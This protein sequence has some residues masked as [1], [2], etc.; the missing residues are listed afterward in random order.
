MKTGYRG[1]LMGLLV[2]GCGGSTLSSGECNS[3]E[4]LRGGQCVVVA[5]CGPGTFQLNGVCLPN[6]TG[7]SAGGIGYGG[8]NGNTSGSGGV[9]AG[10]AGASGSAA[11]A[12]A[13]GGVTAAGTAG[14]DTVH[15]AGMAGGDTAGAAGSDAVGGSAAGVGGSAV[16][17]G[18]SAGAIDGGRD[19]GNYLIDAAHDNLQP[20]DAI[21]SPLTPRWSATFSDLITYPVIAQGRVFVGTNDGTLTAL[22]AET[23]DTLWGPSQF[24]SSDSSARVMVAAE[25]DHLYA[26]MGDGLLSGLDATNGH[27]TWS[28]PLQGQYFFWSAPVAAGGSV[29]VNGL[30]SGGTTYAVNG[31]TGVVSWTAGTFDGS[32]GTV[33]VAGDRVYEAEACDQLSAFESAT[34]K[35][36]WYTVS[37]CTGGGGSTPAVYDGWI[38]ERDWASGNMII[39]ADEVKHGTFSSTIP[40]A[41]AGTTVFYVD[42]GVLSA[43]DIASGTPIWAFSD[44]PGLC[45]APVVAGVRG[46]VFVGSS[47]GRVY[48]LDA[49]SGRKLSS[50]HVD[51]Y[52][53]T[54]EVNALAI[55][56]GRL[57]VPAGKQLIVF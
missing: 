22:D 54:V 36:D 53:C 44:D 51:A 24:P 31:S 14:A 12:F 41:F 17:A 20:N 23:G 47:S 35:L 5:T 38:W 39:G 16:G 1:L 33:A 4:E 49:T 37:G 46:Q 55:A 18:G 21:S 34:G 32:E 52:N 19:S 28:E 56:G 26:L 29:Y 48:E 27:L 50:A 11:G 40:P 30:E 42:A 6:P 10:D 2:V 25:L 45:G 8:S 7:G 57:F 9:G 3:N 15:A 13:T 43:R